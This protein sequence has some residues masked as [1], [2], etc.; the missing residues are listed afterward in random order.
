MEVRHRERAGAGKAVA[1]DIPLLPPMQEWVNVRTLG[2]KGDGSDDT[3]ALQ[4]AIDGHRVLYFPSGTYRVTNTLR[5]RADSVLIGF[6]P[7]T[8]LITVTDEAANF[9]GEGE[10]VPVVES[11]KGGAAIL[12]GI[13]IGTGPW[14]GGRRGWCGVLVLAPWWRM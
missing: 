6:N 13:G 9:T 2:A 1:S 5:L 7:I 12:T 3:A 11:A 8:T 14:I 10:A 4:A